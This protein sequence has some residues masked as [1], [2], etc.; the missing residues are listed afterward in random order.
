ML[1]KGR[2]IFLAIGETKE[3]AQ[4]II[5]GHSECL[6]SGENQLDLLLLKELGI[7]KETPANDSRF[8]FP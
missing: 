3:K 2:E 8:L 4:I 5:L 6:E 7:E 1:F